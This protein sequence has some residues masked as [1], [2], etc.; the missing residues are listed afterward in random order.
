MPR[1]AV[2]LSVTSVLPPRPLWTCL[3]SACLLATAAA[4]STDPWPAE[5]WSQAIN[6]TQVESNFAPGAND[7]YTDLSGA[8]WNTQTRRLWLVRNGPTN[9]TSKVWALREHPAG[10]GPTAFIVDTQPGP[11][12]T[13]LRAEWTSF[14]DAEAITQAD[15]NSPIIYIMAEGEEVIRA[16]DVSI[17]GTQQLLRTWNTLPYLPVSGNKGSEGLAFI[18]DAHLRAANFVDPSGAPRISHGGMGGLMLV[19]HQNGGRIYIFDLSAT[20]AAFQYVGAYA[21]GGTDTSEVTFDRSTSRLYLLHGNDVNTIEVCSLASTQ[22]GAERK[23]NQ[24]NLYDRP[25][26]SPT[27]TNLE[28]LAIVSN[29]DC[30]WQ[31]G[32]GHRTIFETIDGGNAL[33]L[34]QFTQFPCICLADYDGVN[35]PTVQDIFAFISDWFAG[36]PKTDINYDGT[37]SLQDIFDFLTLWFH[38]C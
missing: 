26:G 24:L 4:A 31:G 13:T 34:I 8:F 18:P 3:F 11:N 15:L 32:V 28:G 33:S 5:P 1:R 9:T 23:L 12:S 20:S 35:G 14:N 37:L 36:Q 21:T 17:Y 7:F 19:G 2:F 10:S 16:Y 25:T 6:L 22:V 38:G 27:T 30:V 29:N